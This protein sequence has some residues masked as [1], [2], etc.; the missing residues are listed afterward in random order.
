MFTVRERMKHKL[1]LQ[2][3]A[4]F[5]HTRPGCAAI[6]PG[7]TVRSVCPIRR[8]INSTKM[9]VFPEALITPAEGLR[10][11]QRG[12]T[13]PFAD[14]RCQSHSRLSLMYL[15]EYNAEAEICG[16]W[17]EFHTQRYPCLFQ[18]TSFLMNR[19]RFETTRER[20]GI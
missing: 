11:H 8:A 19:V 6:S 10:Y 13:P 5:C 4:V 2:L 20:N 9:E 17:F 7:E 15:S 14:P 1:P 16:A 18:S 12:H 3:P